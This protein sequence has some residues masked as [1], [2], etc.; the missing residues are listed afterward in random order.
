M[1]KKLLNAFANTITAVLLT[2]GLVLPAYALEIGDQAPELELP[3]D[4]QT[5]K[6][7]KRPGKV[8]YL[9]FWAS[10]CGPC[11]QSFP[12]MNAMQ[13]KYKGQD[14]QVI[15]VNLDTQPE[16][17]EKF[18]SKLPA[19]FTVAYD[20][21]GISAR[22]YGVKGMPTSLLIGKDGKVIYQHIGFNNESREKLEQ[23]I[24]AA[25]EGRK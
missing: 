10:W 3:G 6:I 12:W 24:Q 2:T 13:E 16:D 1:I 23:V 11:R 8:I 4:G 18:L 15:G 14:F 22:S 7:S 25:V 17:A 20:S 21:K 5:V 9:D 19:K